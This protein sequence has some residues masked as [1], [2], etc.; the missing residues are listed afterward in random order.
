MFVWCSFAAASASRLNRMIA[1]VDE[2]QTGREHLERHPA[3][4]RLLLCLV[5][6]AHPAA[7]Q[8]AENLEVAELLRC[9]FHGSG[10]ALQIARR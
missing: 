1:L 8:L 4:E 7:A 9:I 10:M 5:D 2:A 6:H 3:I